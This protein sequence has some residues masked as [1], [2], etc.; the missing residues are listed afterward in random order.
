MKRAVKRCHYVS[1]EVIIGLLIDFIEKVEPSEKV[2]GFIVE[3]IKKT[4]EI[5]A[6]SESNKKIIMTE[7]FCTFKTY[8]D[9]HE[10]LKIVDNIE[11][12]SEEEKVAMVL[13]VK[14]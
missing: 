10:F 13:K 4:G 7:Y 2:T 12:S 5:S 14:F 11:V 8:K 6:W 1:A 3:W 9:V